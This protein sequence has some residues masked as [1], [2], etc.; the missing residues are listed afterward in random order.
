MSI[1]TISLQGDNI[2]L[3]SGG[4]SVFQFTIVNNSDQHKRLGFRVKPINPEH[5][6]LFELQGDVERDFD[7]RETQTVLVKATAPSE[8]GEYAFVLE[9]YS[10]KDPEQM[11]E[12]MKATTNVGAGA[13]PKPEDDE[14]PL[15]W[16]WIVGGSVLLLS[17]IGTVLF[18]V[19]RSPSLP[20]VVAM[21]YDDA[22][23][24][25]SKSDVEINLKEVISEGEE[26][27]A[28]GTVLA[29]E[30]PAGE[31]YP[32]DSIITLTVEVFSVE[33]PELTNITLA[34][35]E[36]I[37]LASELVLG[38]VIEVDARSLSPRVLDQEP[39]AGQRVIPNSMIDLT[40]AKRTVRVPSLSGQSV[41][42]AITSLRDLGLRR[43]KITERKTNATPGVVLST[44]PANGSEVSLGQTVDL[45]VETSRV[46]VPNVTGLNASQAIRE[47][48]AQGLTP[49]TKY[50]R[51]KRHSPG[52]VFQQKPK[53]SSEVKIGSVVNLRAELF[54]KPRLRPTKFTDHILKNQIK[55][56]K[57]GKI[58]LHTSQISKIRGVTP[59]EE[60]EP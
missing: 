50:Q 21:H 34:E 59:I 11:T 6:D 14:G 25:F 4:S 54:R 22:L 41:K 46:R 55:D 53:A 32:E 36:E 16:P 9:V 10:T 43:G 7:D 26:V 29:Q 15:I 13:V 17:I 49:K 33:I 23:H 31:D 30:P 24:E 1:A 51:T 38:K 12:S 44:K 60:V 28:P 5:A 18:F 47:L 37:L 40:I 2:T 56:V 35:A 52:R 8:E 3:K 20:D 27:V 45:L 58:K 39:K 57:L 42:D 19:L 48:K